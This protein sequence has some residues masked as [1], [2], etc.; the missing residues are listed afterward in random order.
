MAVFKNGIFARYNGQIITPQSLGIDYTGIE[1]CKQFFNS[2]SISDEV[3]QYAVYRLVGDL[4]T[5]GIWDKMKAIYPFI[6]QPD[7]SSSFELNLKDP[8]AFKGTFEGDG[9]EFASTGVKGNSSSTYFDTNCNDNNFS[10][11]SISIGCY[12]RTNESS[13]YDFGIYNTTL[14]AGTF[15][16]LNNS[17]EF[18]VTVQ[19]GPPANIV[20][21]TDSRGFFQTSKN[22]ST[23]VLAY[24]NS[25]QVIN[26][27]RTTKNATNTTFYLGA[28]NNGG[29]AAYGFTAK[30]YCLAYIGDGLSA[31][32]MT[33]YYTAVQ[34]FQTT[35]GRQV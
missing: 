12:S 33:N 28:L 20:S 18:R 15:M 1:K 22:G 23:T 10:N 35:L 7:I 16:A 31:T 8:N 2:G 26:T 5:Y 6:G 4:Q 24:K 25:S 14:T 27:T 3:Q 29:T 32:D 17:G 21:N 19:H 11:N 13:E 9:W 30:E 34:R